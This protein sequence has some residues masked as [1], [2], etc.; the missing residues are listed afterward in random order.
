[1]NKGSLREIDPS[2]VFKFHE[3]TEET[4][5]SDLSQKAREG[6]RACHLECH[7]MTR[8]VRGAQAQHEFRKGKSY[9][10][11]LSSFYDKAS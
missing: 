4:C 10:T 6:H 3:E 2:E 9:L 8:T 7:Y 5:H 11:S 1:M